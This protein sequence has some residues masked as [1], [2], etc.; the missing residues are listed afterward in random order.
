MNRSRRKSPVSRL[1]HQF[2]PVGRPQVGAHLRRPDP[3][4]QVVGRVEAV[5]HVGEIPVAAV[6]ESARRRDERLVVGRVLGRVLEV[7]PEPELVAQLR[8][9]AAE[10]EGVEKARRVGAVLRLVAREPEVLGM[11]ARL[12]RERLDEE[13]VDLGERVVAGKPPERVR[14]LRVAARVV[15]GVT[16]LVQERLVVGQA[17]LGARDQMHD[18]RRIGCDHAR[19]RVLLRAVVEVEPDAL[20][21][22]RGRT[23]AP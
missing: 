8:G 5:V 10:E 3:R 12:V 15:E 16:G 18:A 21:R 4:T 2:V 23:R 7:A 9:V 13:R 6:A 11:P 20:A 19:A 14:Q 22:P 1:R 17:T